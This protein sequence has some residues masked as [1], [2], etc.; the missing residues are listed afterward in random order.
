[1]CCCNPLGRGAQIATE[2]RIDQLKSSQ[3]YYTPEVPVSSYLD[4]FCVRLF[5][6]TGFAPGSTGIYCGG[7]G[8]FIS[9]VPVGPKAQKVFKMFR[10]IR[11]PFFQTFTSTADIIGLE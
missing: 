5:L 6:R 2:I 11:V 9:G 3:L 10:G 8:I 1:M 4:G 7:I